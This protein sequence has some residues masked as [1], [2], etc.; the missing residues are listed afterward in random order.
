MDKKI[1]QQDM[2]R[3][4]FFGLTAGLASGFMFSN[5][6][7]PTKVGAAAGEEYARIVVLTDVHCPSKLD[8]KKIE[9]IEEINSWSD[10]SQVVVTGDVVRDTGCTSELER[11]YWIM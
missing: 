4:K 3:R 5:L 9:A 11:M 10:V 8:D 6:F 7:H 1:W 2:S